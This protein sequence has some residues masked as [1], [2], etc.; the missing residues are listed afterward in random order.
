MEVVPYYYKN[1]ESPAAFVIKNIFTEITSKSY[2]LYYNKS[3]YMIEENPCPPN[4][5]LYLDDSKTYGCY[6]DPLSLSILESLTE[7]ISKIMNTEVLPSYSYSR[8]Y[9]KGSK[10]ISHRDRESCEISLTVSLYDSNNG[11]VKYLHIAD[12]DENQCN[13]EDILSIPF[14]VG[15]G[16]LF[17]GS[18]DTNGY[19]HWRD[20]VESDYILQTFLHYVKTNGK[21][22]HNSFEWTKR[23]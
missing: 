12:K 1:N 8:V 22:S 3:Q 4:I 21:F 18:D 15:D 16:L 6:S 2:N 9:T 19:Y 10:L 5:K 20:T 11:D 14:S 13:K 23:Q 7:E 17:F